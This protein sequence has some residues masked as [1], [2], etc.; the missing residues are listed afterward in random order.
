MGLLAAGVG[1][2]W[3]WPMVLIVVGTLLL[4]AAVIDV[5]SDMW[6]KP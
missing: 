1:W 4:L 5:L 6:G 2:Q 3:G